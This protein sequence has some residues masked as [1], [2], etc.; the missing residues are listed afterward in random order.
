MATSSARR[1]AGRS[2]ASA[3]HHRAMKGDGGFARGLSD[4][5]DVLAQALLTAIMIGLAGLVT[6][7]VLG[8]IGS[9]ISRHASFGIFSAMLIL[10]AH[11]MMMFYL[12]GKGKA[13]KDAL[14]EGGY[15][16]SDQRYREF[17]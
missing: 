4:I 6:T 17:V 12:I 9:D 10:L 8:L 5:L 7:A 16:A 3:A 11:S 13:V 14:T 1:G 2:S 15:P